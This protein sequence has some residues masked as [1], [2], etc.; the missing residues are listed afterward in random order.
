MEEEIKCSQG[1]M[2]EDLRPK[3]IE[4]NGL[5]KKVLYVK[6]LTSHQILKLLM[7]SL[8]QVALVFWCLVQ[9]SSRIFI[10]EIMCFAHEGRLVYSIPNKGFVN[11]CRDL[12][13]QSGTRGMG[14]KGLEM[15]DKA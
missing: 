3:Q 14:A 15:K 5:D 6:Y 13:E 11:G 7:V 4:I 8:L 9:K 1:S 2:L 12:V 10:V